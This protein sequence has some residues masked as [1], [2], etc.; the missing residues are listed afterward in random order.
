LLVFTIDEVSFLLPEALYH[1]D[2]Q[3]RR[4]RG[5]PDVPFGGVALILAGDFWQKP[6]PGSTSLAEVLAATDLPGL[7]RQKPLDP[8]G[9]RAKG[10]A[11]FRQ[12]RRTMLT[13][14][15]RAA[16]DPEFQDELLHLRD[17]GCEVP[18]PT[19]LVDA[20]Q[21]ISASDIAEHPPW[22][23]ATIAVLSNYERHHLNRKQAQAFAL[24]HSLPLV[25]WKRQVTGRACELLDAGT[26]DELYEHE[27]GLWSVFVRGAPA[28]MTENIQPTKYLVNGA[29][30][31]MHSLS[32]S[33]DAPAELTDALAA[34][35]Y[36]V[37]ILPEPP[38]CVNFQVS[39]PDGDDGGGIESLVDDAIVALALVAV[40]SRCMARS[41]NSC[42]SF[43]RS[44]QRP[45]SCV[46]PLTKTI[47]SMHQ[48][49]IHVS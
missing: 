6:P 9:N 42:V 26:L 2:V 20:L 18:V 3:L 14:Q 17:T 31:Y 47:S 19:S 45:H 24:A 36:S 32:F 38:L 46:C 40:L 29:C 48:R 44:S 35:G 25:M 37:V 16:T 27:P 34:P 5:L 1:V 30:G 41:C 22:A 15:M 10:L 39:L 43:L 21:E 8:L 4:L 13:Q 12:A 28:M 33:A 11:I 23:F 7:A 49:W